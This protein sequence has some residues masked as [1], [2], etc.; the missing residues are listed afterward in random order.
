MELDL[1]VTMR[2]MHA[3]LECR[4]YLDSTVGGFGE[5]FIAQLN[6]D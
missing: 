6:L 2:R 1:E 3:L 5:I 4:S